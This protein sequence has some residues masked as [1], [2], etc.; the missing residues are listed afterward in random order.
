LNRG[1]GKYVRRPVRVGLRN[2]DQVEILDGL[3]PADQV[4]I[5]GNHVLFSLFGGSAQA[6]PST[7]SNIAKANS[8]DLAPAALQ[9]ARGDDAIVVQ[10]VVELPT[11]RKVFA[12]SRIEGRIGRIFVEHSQPVAAGQVLA[13]IE[14]LELRNLQ[15]ELL[16]TDVKLSWTRQR[17]GR[18]TQLVQQNIAS[19]KELWQLQTDERV[20]A[21]KRN[22]LL[23]TL[24]LLGIPDEEVMRL[25]ATDLSST[26]CDLMLVRS[27]PVRAPIAGTVADFDIVPGQVVDSQSTLFEIH[28]ASKVWVRGY[29]FQQDAARV[30][31]GQPVRLTF[32][33]DPGVAVE[34]NVV[35]LS[36][37]LDS[38][39]RVLPMWV[40]VDN[41]DGRLIQG[42]WARMEIEVARSP[43]A[44]TSDIR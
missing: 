36:P 32:S 16:E 40:E 7:Y 2:H 34:G 37:V 42:M 12:G 11:D 13:E 24:S 17:A 21:A 29:V 15:G 26:D 8:D 27:L 28:D 10:G 14:S 22:S 23:R 5:T 4:V 35:R 6:N 41:P 43:L 1:E 19:Q 20:L 18:L 44:A 38:T 3:F 39:E 33:S 9:Q 30:E 31:V 25:L